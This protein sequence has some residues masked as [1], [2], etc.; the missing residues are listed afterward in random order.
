ML[1]RRI[2]RIVGLTM[3]L[4]VFGASQQ[5]EIKNVPVEWTSPASG[6]EMYKAYCAVC[7]GVNGNGHGPAADALKVSP[8]DLTMLAKGNG[9]VYPSDH[10]RAAI[11]GDP[12]L[13]SHGA[14]EMPVWGDLFW[15]MSQAHTSEVQLRVGNL[16]KHIQTLQAK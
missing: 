12:R 11:E 14:K 9:G 2:F 15:R 6:A 4:A 10:V 5:K 1:I 8:P 7:H 3:C 16:S 13:S